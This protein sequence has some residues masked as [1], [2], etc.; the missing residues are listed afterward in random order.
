[1]PIKFLSPLIN[2]SHAGFT[3]TQFSLYAALLFVVFY[4][5][6]F[7]SEILG[8]VDY[9]KLRGALFILNIALVLW[10]LTFII[11]SLITQRHLGKIV[12]STLFFI[13]AATAYF[14]D[15]YGIVIHRLMIQNVMETDVSEAKGL[16]SF[17]L[18]LYIIAFGLAP[19]LLICKINIRYSSFKTELWQKTKY[20]AL[21]FIACLLLI[22]SMSMDYASFFRNHKNIRQMANPLNFIYAGASY[23]TTSN[24]AIAVKPIENDAAI[25][26]LGKGQAKPTLL[27]LV[28]GETARADHFGINGYERDTTPLIAQQNIINFPKVTSCGTETAVSVPCMFSALGRDNYSDKKA[29]TQEG[30]LDVIHHAGIDVL[31]RDNNSSCKGTCDRVAYEDMRFLKVDGLCNESECFDEILLHQLDEKMGAATKNRII[32]LHQKGSHGPDYFNRYPSDRVVFT[33]ECKTNQ[34]Q[35]CKK[36]EVINAFDN[37]IHYTDYFLNKTIEWLKT[38]SE[39]NTSLLYLSDHGESLGE[40]NLYLHGMPYAIAPME[41]KHIPFFLWLSDGY[42]AANSIDSG[43]LKAISSSAYSHDNLFHTL[44]GMLNIETAVYRGQLDIIKPCRPLR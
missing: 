21:A 37:T 35:N 1:M 32:V 16:I 24:K 43:C 3:S 17:S 7:F 4:N 13:A 39:Y 10:L 14:M 25:S 40:K 27:I 29:K 44:L 42:A 15:A 20:S 12:L 26:P 23:I 33:P 30:V 5:T 28:V 41:Q 8:L 2:K 19:T 38:K 6:S 22:V 31:W 36:E 11:I 9:T 18:L 34:L